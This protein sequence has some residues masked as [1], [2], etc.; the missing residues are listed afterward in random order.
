MKENVMNGKVL[1]NA[2]GRKKVEERKPAGRGQAAHRALL[3][4]G[5]IVGAALLIGAMV[6]PVCAQSYPNKAIR[7][8]IPYVPGGTTDLVGRIIGPKYAEQLGQ[9]VVIENRGGAGG[10]LAAEYVAKSPPDGYSLVLINADYPIS[11]AIYNKLNYDQLKD[12]API[13]L[14]AEVPLMICVRLDLPVKT[15]K[16]FVEYARANPGK[17][18]FGSSGVGTISHLPMEMLNKEAK[19]NIKHVAYKGSGASRVALMSGEIDSLIM[20]SSSG[21]GDVEAGKIRPLAVLSSKR[22][23][24]LP[25]VPTT[26]EAGLV[27]FE[28][29]Y[30]LGILAPAKTPRDIVN[31]LHAEWNKIAAMPDTKEKIEKTGCDL[32]TS[33]TPESLFEIIK[34]DIAR[35]SKIVEDAKITKF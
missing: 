13:G 22:W 3:I 20:A 24:L 29:P 1:W 17:L 35:W 25:N 5:A 18:N 33:P 32:L 21:I 7:L 23:R 34:A 12:L 31:R 11:S 14:V 27:Y 16:E 8:I 2:Q 28:F 4:A 19:I 6:A 9:P 30:W 15:L 26:K 10:N